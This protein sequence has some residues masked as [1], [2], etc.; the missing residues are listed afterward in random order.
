MTRAT[1]EPSHDDRP[2][3]KQLRVLLL[4]TAALELENEMHFAIMRF[5]FDAG[6]KYV[7][8]WISIILEEGVHLI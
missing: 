5:S 1:E 7:G 2:P 8:A 3:L 6:V 4:V